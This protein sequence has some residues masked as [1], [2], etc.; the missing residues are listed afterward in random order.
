MFLLLDKFQAQNS[1]NFNWTKSFGNSGKDAGNSIVADKYGNVYL[2]GTF[3]G[4]VDFDPSPNTFFL[5]SNG[6]T[7]VFI[8]KFGSNG[9]HLWTIS[10]GGK[11]YEEAVS[12]KIDL[13]GNLFSVG[14][15]KDTVD[16]DPGIGKYEMHSEISFIGP[17][18]EDIFISKLTNNGEFIWAKS[19][20]YDRIDQ[21]YDLGI[22]N[23][24]NVYI[25]GLLTTWVDCDP[26]IAM[27]IVG[28]TGSLDVFVLK[29]DT[30]GNFVW[31]SQFG[32]QKFNYTFCNAISTDPAGN[33][34]LTGSFQGTLGFGLGNMFWVRASKGQEDG[35]VAKID[36]SGNL[37]WSFQIGGKGSDA[38]FDIKTDYQNN[39]VVTGIFDD[40][41]AF[42]GPSQ[43][44]NLIAKY[45]NTFVS[46]FTQAGNLVWA[47][48]FGA[49]GKCYPQNTSSDNEGS[50]YVFG[51][52]VD[53][54]DFDPGIGVVNLTETSGVAT[55]ILKLDENGNFKWVKKIG[56]RAWSNDINVDSLSNI[57]VTGFFSNTA[58]FDPPNNAACSSNGDDDVFIAKYGNAD[59]FVG[60][61]HQPSVNKF[62]VSPNPFTSTFTINSNVFNAPCHII[63]LNAL[64]QVVY[65]SEVVNNNAVQITLQGQKGMYLLRVIT[66]NNMYTAKII[67]D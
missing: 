33:T 21:V 19:I 59:N 27:H 60:L 48:N 63:V 31:A 26:S 35:F 23:A 64:G 14:H 47:K 30:G 54:V 62:T 37:I 8:T 13:E 9:N 39:V 56:V 12:L 2:M 38:G 58:D 46:K 50:I 65:E 44:V 11:N 25:A 3:S 22:D 55:F 6:G 1:Q 17:I 18:C 53:T 66:K 28:A 20:G 5:S 45:G 10:F 4:T 32:G 67:K 41:V 49:Q 24:S 61:N 43:H 51:R 52:F 16:F 34:Y 7:D 15:F 40:T 57:Y 36:E 29:L 42:G